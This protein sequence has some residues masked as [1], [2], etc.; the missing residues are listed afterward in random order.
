MRENIVPFSAEARRKLCLTNQSKNSERLRRVTDEVYDSTFPPLVKK[1]KKRFNKIVAEAIV[2]VQERFGL[3]NILSDR[4]VDGDSLPPFI[5]APPESDEASKNPFLGAGFQQRISDPK[6]GFRLVPIGKKGVQSEEEFVSK[7]IQVKEY[8]FAAIMAYDDD[9][10]QAAAVATSEPEV[11]CQVRDGRLY[12]LEGVAKL[13]QPLENKAKLFRPAHCLR[14]SP[15]HRPILIAVVAAAMDWPDLELPWDIFWGFNIVGVIPET[16]VFRPN[17]EK[18]LDRPLADI[19]IAGS[20][21]YECTN[22][23]WA[24]KANRRRVNDGDHIIRWKSHVEMDRHE[25]IGPFS[26][27]EVNAIFGCGAWK[28]M[29]R[30]PA[31]SGNRWREVDSGKAAGHNPATKCLERI[32][33]EDLMTPDR[34]AR[35]MREQWE[36]LPEGSRAKAFKIFGYTEDLKRAYRQLKKKFDTDLNIFKFLSKVLRHLKFVTHKF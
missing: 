3:K 4:T 21:G 36:A 10:R 8:P 30:F 19:N 28:T 7:A 23:Q 32:T 35:V 5:P 22:Q 31:W 12:L 24:A 20:P 11:A 14:V 16:G 17:L 26:L 15:N 18:V 2:L 9:M 13:I 1:L 34:L 27:T 25:S 33:C 29:L 6:T